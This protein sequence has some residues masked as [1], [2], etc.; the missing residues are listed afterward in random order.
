MA[1]SLASRINKLT[2]PRDFAA[3]FKDAF[4]K[5]VEAQNPPYA[6]SNHIKPS[7]SQC[8]RQMYYIVTST[9]PDKA[10]KSTYQKLLISMDGSSTHNDIQGVIAKAA[11]QGIIFI[12]P[13]EAVARAQAEGSLTIVKPSSHDDKTLYEI[14]CYNPE[15]DLSFKFDGVIVFD[16]MRVI[17]EIK[18]EEYYKWLKRIAIEPQHLIQA[19][20]YSLALNIDYVLF[21]Y[22]D[23]NLRD[24]KT[25]LIRVT[26]E[27]R[28]EQSAR[29][30][31]VLTCRDNKLVPQKEVNKSC[32]YCLYAKKCRAQGPDRG[33]PLC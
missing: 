4:T 21:I 25:Y 15:F 2:S 6:G 11:P 32:Q 16:N 1:S 19:T 27:M 3:S 30:S 18:T 13:Q 22:V 29:I 17:I 14:G 26:D 9:E 20:Q 7:K 23:R 33:K 28:A 8:L 12:P 5:A 24:I 31:D 10:D